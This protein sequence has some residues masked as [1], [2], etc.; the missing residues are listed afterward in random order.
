MSADDNFLY[1][2][3]EEKAQN[4]EFEQLNAKYTAL[5]KENATL[6]QELT[7]SKTQIIFITEQKEVV[8]K[9]MMSLFN[10]AIAELKRKDKQVIELTMKL[11]G[12][13]R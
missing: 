7:D 2:D 9:N 1:G 6:K 13:G 10:T 11:K 12:G 8:E 5:E 3:L 4:V